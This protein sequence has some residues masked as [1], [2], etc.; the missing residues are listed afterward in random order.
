MTKYGHWIVVDGVCVFLFNGRM[1]T[2]TVIGVIRTVSMSVSSDAASVLARPG[3]YVIRDGDTVLY[4]GSA[5][6]LIRR[7]FIRLSEIKGDGTLTL[8]PCPDVREARRLER[9]LIG[10]LHPTRN[11]LHNKKVATDVL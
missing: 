3:V 9:S 6:K 2:D 10:L 5:S 1:F 8:Y 4:V 11:V 7:A